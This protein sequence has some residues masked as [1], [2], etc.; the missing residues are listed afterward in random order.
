MRFQEF[1][2][3]QLLRSGPHQVEES[4]IIAFARA[5]DPQW[6]HTDPQRAAA[7]RWHGLIASG[8]HTCSIAMRLI[9]EG[10]LRQSDSIGSPG[11]TYLKWLAP[12]RPGDELRVEAKVL[13]TRASASG[14]TG[15]IRWQWRL[16]NQDDTAVLDLE[17]T[18]L[19][20]LRTDGARRP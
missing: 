13:E 20:D 19:F 11:L 9:C 6:F 14:R 7:G 3:G 15:I 10:P 18:S 5:Y 16:L 2:V 8:W 17:A 4:E 12:V 1:Q